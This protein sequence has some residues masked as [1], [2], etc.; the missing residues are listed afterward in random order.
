MDTT[1]GK[2]LQSYLLKLPKLTS[3]KT[4]WVAAIY[5]VFLAS[6]Y[7]FLKSI[8]KYFCKVFV[9]SMYVIRDVDINSPHKMDFID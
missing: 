3:C 4:Q 8:M 9:H 7:F 5:D 6:K 1:K 2:T